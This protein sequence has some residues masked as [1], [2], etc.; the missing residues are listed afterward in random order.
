MS[1]LLIGWSEIDTTPQGKVDLYG[2]YYHRVSQGV[3][4][5]LS[6]TAL[7]MESDNGQQV[8]MVS[9]DVCGIRSDF[10]DDLRNMLRPELP[11]LDVAMIFLNVIHTHSAPSVNPSAPI[12]WLNEL[13]G[14]L[15]V[16][17][18]R[19]FLL[20]KIKTVVIEAWQNRKPGGIAHA[21]GSARVGHCRR[22]SY[23]NGTA[24]MYG[25]TNR[26]DFTAMECG[27][28]S[29][30][31]LLFTFDSQSQPTGVILN[32]ACP[33][34]VMEATYQISSDF[35]GETKRLLKE[36]FGEKFHMLGQ[37]SAAGCQ[38][39]RDL[40]R[41]YRGEPD[42][43]HEDGV[44]EIGQRLKSTVENVFEKAATKIDFH[45]SFA[46]TLRRFHYLSVALQSKII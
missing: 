21:L 40:T 8:V 15:K 34:Q 45:P 28:D 44:A 23:T 18:H 43:W 6:A 39:P 30:V 26:E 14:V 17:D 42:F 5:R 33:A 19:Q 16:A 12:G 36:R 2:Q 11:D 10:Q 32:L 7:A 37:I 20:E 46:T 35:T 13:P 3:H 38:A 1:E 29:G 9:L 25:Q 4:S 24:Q 22:A 41:N 31:D 27:E